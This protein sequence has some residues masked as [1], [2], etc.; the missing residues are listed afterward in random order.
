MLLRTTRPSCSSE[1][2]LFEVS[3][4]PNEEMKE[5][6]SSNQHWASRFLFWGSASCCAYFI[7]AIGKTVP[8]NNSSLCLFMFISP[9]RVLALAGHLQ[10]EYTIIFGKLPHY[11]GPV[12]L[13]YRSHSVYGLANTAAVYLICGNVK[14]LKC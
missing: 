3:K 14:T 13:C 11:N 9:L 5:S 4:S 10:A 1:F 6:K 8:R 2:L 7:K 12:V